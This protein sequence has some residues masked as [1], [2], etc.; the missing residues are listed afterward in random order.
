MS[1]GRNA[2]RFSRRSQ[3]LT[4]LAAIA[5]VASVPLRYAHVPLAQI[6]MLVLAAAALVSSIVDRRTTGT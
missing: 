5:L 2:A 1:R 3:I 6:V 4:L